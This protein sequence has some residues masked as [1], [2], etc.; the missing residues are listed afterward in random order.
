M[1]DEFENAIPTL[2][3]G[4]ISI[5]FMFW[6]FNFWAGKGFDVS[7]GTRI[8]VFIV[9]IPLSYVIINHFANKD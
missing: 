6:V 7:W 4:L 3:I 1:F 8:V 9:M 2:I 5:G